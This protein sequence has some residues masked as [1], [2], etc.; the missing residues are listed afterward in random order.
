MYWRAIDEGARQKY[1]SSTHTVVH[2]EQAHKVRH[3]LLDTGILWQPLCA[4]RIRPSSYRIEVTGKPPSLLSAG[5][6]RLL[7][8]GASELQ[9][10]YLLGVWDSWAGGQDDD[11]SPANFQGL[12]DLA[13]VEKSLSSAIL[14]VVS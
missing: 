10:K 13:P 5:C 8:N 4:Q 12:D 14:L 9:P 3:S 7:W 2:L 6:V 11:I 1:P